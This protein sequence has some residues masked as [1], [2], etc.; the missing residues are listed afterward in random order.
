MP[1]IGYG[2]PPTNKRRK[3]RTTR[4]GSS[5]MIP[6]LRP[7]IG[8]KRIMRKGKKGAGSRRSRRSVPGYGSRRSRRSVPGYGRR[9]AGFKSF[10]KKMFTFVR[11]QSQC[12]K[13]AISIEYLDNFQ[14]SWHVRDV[15][16]CTADLK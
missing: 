1:M 11:P 4:K 3:K 7:L 10:M 12:R 6:H 14:R 5:A 8:V 16:R 2:I 9:G 15:S 13:F